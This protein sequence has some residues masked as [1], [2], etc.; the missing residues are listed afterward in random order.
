LDREEKKRRKQRR[1][2]QKLNFKQLT[3]WK[4][5]IMKDFEHKNKKLEAPIVERK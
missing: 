1:Q 3:G 4:K 5:K 2:N